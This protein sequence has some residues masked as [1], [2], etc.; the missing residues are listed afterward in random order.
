MQV[1][2]QK[3][4]QLGLLVDWSWGEGKRGIKRSQDFWNLLLSV[5]R[6]V[7]SLRKGGSEEAGSIALGNPRIQLGSD[8]RGW[9]EV[10]E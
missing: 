4:R 1:A 8:V 6:V 3:K 5:R 10:Q 9:L 2:Y 7:M